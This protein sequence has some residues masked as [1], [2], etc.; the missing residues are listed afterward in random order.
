[1]KATR[2]LLQAYA[3]KHPTLAATAQIDALLQTTSRDATPAELALEHQLR[4]HGVPFE[5]E[6][7]FHP[8]RGWRFDFAI[9]HKRLAI[10]LEGGV[11]RLRDRYARDLEK[12]NAAQLLGWC[13][14]RY[15]NPHALDGTACTAVLLALET[16]HD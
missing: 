2:K 6:Y 13:V 3:R 8:D 9:P 16:H 4:E 7:K 10:E 12:Y 1:M 14:L 15:D 5:R 11:H